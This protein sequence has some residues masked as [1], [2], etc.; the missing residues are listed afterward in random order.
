MSCMALI[1]EEESVPS[2]RPRRY[3]FGKTLKRLPLFIVGSSESLRSRHSATSSDLE[4]GWE[5]SSSYSPSSSG[6]S[7]CGRLPLNAI[8]KNLCEFE[9]L[10]ILGE[11]PVVRGTCRTLKNRQ[12]AERARAFKRCYV[13]QMNR[14]SFMNASHLSLHCTCFGSAHL[15]PHTCSS[16]GCRKTFTKTRSL[17]SCCITAAARVLTAYARGAGVGTFGRVRLVRSRADGRHFALKSMRKA[18]VLRM[19]QVEHVLNEKNVLAEVQ[20]PFI[21]H[22]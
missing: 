19:K 11:R 1:A 17:K 15:S 5:E 9:Q 2:P 21:V 8:Y 22:L 10:H 16:T 12:V 13:T 7:E 14:Y 3:R 18:D 6:R 4:S 20:H